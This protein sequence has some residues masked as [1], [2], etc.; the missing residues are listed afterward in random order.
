MAYFAFDDTFESK[1][2]NQRPRDERDFRRVAPPFFRLAARSLLGHLSGSN[3]ASAT[4]S[5]PSD[6]H[7]PTTALATSPAHA[8][9]ASRNGVQKTRSTLATRA[10][11]RTTPGAAGTRGGAE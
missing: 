9:N 3:G 6:A 11:T 8:E 10:S 5:L 4:G 7:A 2:K 1:N